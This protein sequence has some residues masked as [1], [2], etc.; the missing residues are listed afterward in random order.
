MRI[1]ADEA[2]LI[3]DAA[4]RILDGD[5]GLTTIAHE[6]KSTA[7]GRRWYPQ[8]VRDV[9]TSPTIA[10][11]RI[12]GD[13]FLPGE[14][15]PILDRATGS[16][17][18]RSWPIPA[19]ARHRSRSSLAAVEQAHAVRSLRRTLPQASVRRVRT[20]PRYTCWG[21]SQSVPI[22]AV[23]DLVST[24]VLDLIDRPTWLD[25]G[26]PGRPRTST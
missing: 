13:A 20:W 26:P 6:W 1:E 9:L 7:P 24:A 23:D 19:D 17:C 25:S 10:G 2:A 4:T 3:R 12:D 16:R 15:A 22:K 5:A 18:V 8:V 14:W 21:C 11:L